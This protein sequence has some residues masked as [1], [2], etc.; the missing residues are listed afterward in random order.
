MPETDALQR[1]ARLFKIVT[2]VRSHAS[3]Q[4]LGR[5]V[6]AEACLC[7]ERT[8][9]RD[10]ELLAEAGIPITYDF[11]RCAYAL[12]EGSG[13]VFPV[14]SLTPEDALTLA[15]VRGIVGI[16][17]MPHQQ[18]LLST[19]EKLTASLSPALRL[20]FQQAASAFQP[21][22]PVRDYSRAPLSL[23]A[24]AAQAQETVELDYS[25]RSAG[26]RTWRRVDPYVVET[27]EGLFWE[28]HGWCHSRQA[29][30][31]FALDQVLEA[32]VTG[33]QFAWHEA[34]WSKFS[35]TR[36]IVG[37]LR[38]GRQVDVRVRFSAEVVAYASSRHWPAG[39]TLSPEP[40]GTALLTGTAQGI[41]GIIKE[42]LPW[43]RHAV[44]EGGA[45][46]RTAMAEEVRAMAALYDQK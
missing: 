39:L 31:T 32:R 10:I 19:L 9:Q 23:L 20:L 41:G 44:V 7:S 33:E 1:V 17:G 13:W 35:Q 8:I 18:S 38:G 15:L 46:L 43:R 14:L 42:V 36:G 16:E 24:Q 26:Q 29:L 34:E 45:L 4:P 22:K 21:G 37:G 3:Y 12:P 40:D 30:R 5:G 2:L 25:S 28:L 27:R 6:L 11:S